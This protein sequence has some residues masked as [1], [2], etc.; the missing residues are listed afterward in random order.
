MH[1]ERILQ[2]ELK[3]TKAHY[4]DHPD[5]NMLIQALFPEGDAGD[6]RSVHYQRTLVRPAI[7]WGALFLHII[8]VL[9]AAAGVFYLTRYWGAARWTAMFIAAMFTLGYCIVRL[10]RIILC[11]VRLYQHFAPDYIR[12]RCRFEPSC[13]E[14][15]ILAV[16]QY[17]AFKGTRKGIQ[18]LKRCNPQG[19]GYDWP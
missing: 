11:I 18:R 19:G 6:P 8:V 4:G 12:N 15:M 14:Y 5:K 9:L 17:G 13:S 16:S 1:N 10:K 2:S 7:Q 3:E